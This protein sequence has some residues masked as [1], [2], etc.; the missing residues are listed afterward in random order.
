MKKIYG[1]NGEFMNYIVWITC[2]IGILINLFI[3]GGGLINRRDDRLKCKEPI[4]PNI[5][6]ITMMIA[7]LLGSGRI[8][9]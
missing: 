5:V 4:F 6:A 3:V 9:S 1:H 2:G 8:Y 7:I